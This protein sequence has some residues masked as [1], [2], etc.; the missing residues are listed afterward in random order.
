MSVNN[1]CN[2]ILL[3]G[4]NKDKFCPFNCS[5]GFI[6]CNR[7]ILK[8]P[9]CMEKISYKKNSCSLNCSHKFH[10]S[11]IMKLYKQKFDFNNKCPMCRDEFTE[12]E[13]SITLP[14]SPM[15]RQ[16]AV[17][18]N[19]NEITLESLFIPQPRPLQRQVAIVD[20]I[21]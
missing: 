13:V 21:D 11:C 3:S 20:L 7:H 14:T 2:H 12:K 18:T 17:A 5:I 9:I 8:C 1:T 19:V 16:Q 6:Y 15:E 10:F 4:P